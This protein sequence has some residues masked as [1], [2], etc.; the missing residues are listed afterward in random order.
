MSLIPG[1][2]GRREV[3]LPGLSLQTRPVEDLGQ[4]VEKKEGRR[5]K[6]H[7]I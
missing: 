1:R 4:K 5:V 7:C 2:A 6:G 3:S